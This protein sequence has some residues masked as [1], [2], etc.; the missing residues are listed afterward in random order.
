MADEKEE[1]S[2]ISEN[3]NVE[4][5]SEIPSYLGDVGNTLSE[6]SDEINDKNERKRMKKKMLK[7]AK[8]AKT[9]ILERAEN[10]VIEE[11][12]D[13]EIITPKLDISQ[14]VESS[15]LYQNQEGDPQVQN[16]MWNENFGDLLK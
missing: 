15:P 14:D 16:I 10:Y 4:D 5:K 12:T 8:R 13:N 7:R 9:E 1:I 11:I 3:R 2:N 6:D